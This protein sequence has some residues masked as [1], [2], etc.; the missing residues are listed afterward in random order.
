LAG[1]HAATLV[2]PFN[3]FAPQTDLEFFGLGLNSWSMLPIVLLALATKTETI[4][5]PSPIPGLEL[6][7]HH[8]FSTATTDRPR[9]VVLFA[10]GNLVPTAG[11]A[12]FKIDGLSWMDD[13]A[14]HGYDVWSFDYLGYGGSSRYTGAAIDSGAGDVPACAAQLERAARYIAQRQHVAKLFIIGDSY[15]SEVAGLFATRASDLVER[16][17]LF[18]PVTPVAPDKRTPSSAD[19]T[20]I[21]ARGY[22]T[23]ADIWTIYA[24]WLPPGEHAGLDHDFFLNVWG[25][26]YL[27]TDPTSASRTPPSV[28]VTTGPDVDD[29]EIAAGRFPYDPSQIRVATMILMGEWDSIATEDGAKRLFDALTNAPLKRRVV[30]GG[31]T[32]I[33]QLERRSR[34]QAFEEVRAF[35]K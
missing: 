28:Q 29:R 2:S 10:E 23:P 5:I 33:V 8:E 25:R 11:N 4:R 13:L 17:I 15:G 32:H 22:V 9:A 16:L 12:A 1:C 14:Q 26:A 6:A 19:T 24:S 35:L 27:A 31:G 18:A 3:F 34:M 30:I 7:L 20:P 21:P